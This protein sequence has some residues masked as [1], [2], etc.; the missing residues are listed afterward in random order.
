MVSNKRIQNSSSFDQVV[1]E[2]QLKTKAIMRS[3]LTFSNEL[4]LETQKFSFVISKLI[5]RMTLN[6]IVRLKKKKKKKKK[7]LKA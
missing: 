4:L 5:Y 2:L 1:F 7:N 3:D 6:L